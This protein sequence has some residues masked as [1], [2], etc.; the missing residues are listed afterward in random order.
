MH[1]IKVPI[2]LIFIEL[3]TLV[4]TP[5][6]I[7]LLFYYSFYHTILNLS[8]IILYNLGGEQLVLQNLQLVHV[9]LRINLYVSKTKMVLL[10]L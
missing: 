7:S 6:I 8:Y 4:L 5:S 9:Y 2:S 10:L 1:Y 3:G